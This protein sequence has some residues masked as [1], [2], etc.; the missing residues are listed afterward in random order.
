MNNKI[1]G[2]SLIMVDLLSTGQNIGLLNFAFAKCT[3]LIN[4]IREFFKN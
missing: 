4:S 2:A 1:H 3:D